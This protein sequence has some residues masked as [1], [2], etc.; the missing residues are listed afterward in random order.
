MSIALDYAEMEAPGAVQPATAEAPLAPLSASDLDHAIELLQHADRLRAEA[1][2]LL[3]P[4]AEGDLAR[5]L[6]YVS[7]ERLVAHRTGGGNSAG[8]SL[9]Q[10]A[11]HLDRFPQTASALRSGALSWAQ[12][13]I[14]AR[15]AGDD[16]A[17]HYAEHEGELLAAA[18]GCEP[19][20]YR[21]LVRTW[22]TSVDRELDE[23]D[24]ERSW[25]RRSLTMQLAFDGSCHGRFRLDP[26]GAEIVAQALDSPPDPADTLPEPRTLA[27]RRADT[28]VE[29]CETA[30]GGGGSG[31]AGGGRATVDVVIDV[32]TLG[33]GDPFAVSRLRRELG[34]G[35]P[36]S[37]PGV[38]RL[39]CDASFR[40]LVTDG[41]RTVLAYNRATPDI[42]DG[43]R[44]AVRLR[45]RRCTFRGCDR[46]WLWC[47]IHHIVPRHRGG[48]TTLDNLTLLC[49]FHHGTVHEG[50]WQLTR[51]P[52]G[53]IETTSP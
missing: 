6:G 36:I 11:S 32:E 5:W 40:A 35:G 43:L 41:P 12:A 17:G 39:L 4:F 47:D 48:P 45:D 1:A 28:L 22:Q 20:D 15:A 19:D 33:G 23:A 46:S 3:G 29:L 52:D 9:V 7:L 26:T 31:P 30:T 27:Q 37:G 44:R 53:A 10:V 38:D 24:A 34:R 50:R 14:L 21:Q 2:M 51:G 18:V 16:R 25:R 8:R 49:R 13:E 42:P